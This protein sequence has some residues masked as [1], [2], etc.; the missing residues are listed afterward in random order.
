MAS[1]PA[2]VCNMLASVCTVS[3]RGPL[4]FRELK[5]QHMVL[6][7]LP[8][9]RVECLL[10]AA[11]PLHMTDVHRYHMIYD[12]DPSHATHQQPHLA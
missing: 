12:D 5:T 10:H 6:L 9:I 1:V 7:H 2:R 3:A 4:P 8:A 11:A